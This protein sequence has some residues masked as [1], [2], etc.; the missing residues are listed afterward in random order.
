[1]TQEY[2]KGF[3]TFPKDQK[4][5]NVFM[6]YQSGQR[7][8]MNVPVERIDGALRDGWHIESARDKA[9]REWGESPEGQDLSSQIGVFGSSLFDSLLMGAPE[10]YMKLTGS[11]LESAKNE[12]MKREFGLLSGL[13]TGIG[14]LANFLVTGSLGAGVKI[15]GGKAASAAAA[16]ILSARMMAMPGKKLTQAAADKAAKSMARK[17]AESVGE[18]GIVGTAEMAP[19]AATEAIWGDPS[20]AGEYLMMGGL[21]GGGAGGALSIGGSAARGAAKTISKGSNILMGNEA[22]QNIGI[23]SLAGVTG[24]PESAIRYNL[25]NPGKVDLADDIIPQANYVNKLRDE[26]VGLVDIG[27]EK[28]DGAQKHYDITEQDLTRNMEHVARSADDAVADRLEEDVG[29]KL[30]ELL[31]LQGQ[32]TID[33]LDTA[34]ISIGKHVILNDVNREIKR[35]SKPGITGDT[36]KATLKKLLALHEDI[37]AIPGKGIDGPSAKRLLTSMRDDSTFS[38]TKAPGTFDQGYSRVVKGISRKLSDRIK[39]KVPEY[40]KQMELMAPL[41]DAAERMSTIFK[42]RTGRLDI[43][44]IL[45]TPNNILKRKTGDFAKHED[46]NKILI[47]LDEKA[48]PGILTEYEGMIKD[49]I[50]AIQYMEDHKTM[51]RSKNLAKK[52]QF[53]DKYLK[54]QAEPL[55]TAKDEL[56]D[57]ESNYKEMKPILGTVG[58]GHIDVKKLRRIMQNKGDETLD[59]ARKK[60]FE[61]N[62][63]NPDDIEA[64]IVKDQFNKA[65]PA[66]SK[67]VN[68][69]AITGGFFGGFAGSVAGVVAGAVME[70]VGGKLAKNMTNGKMSSWLST[71]KIIG[72]MARKLDTI[73]KMIRNP[74]SGIARANIERLGVKLYRD[75]YIEMDERERKAAGMTSTKPTPENIDS[76]EMNLNFWKGMTHRD[77]KFRSSPDVMMNEIES[78]TEAISGDEDLAGGMVEHMI[79]A[80]DYLSEV[81]PKDPMPDSPFIEADEKWEPSDY[82]L[83]VFSQQSLAVNNP[84]VIVDALMDD[85]LTREMTDAVSATSPSIMGHVQEKMVEAIAEHPKSFDYTKRISGSYIMGMELD[86]TASPESYLYYQSAMVSDQ[87]QEQQQQGNFAPDLKLDAQQ[88][89][90]KSQRIQGGLKS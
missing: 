90:T 87:Q 38:I 49:K 24:A 32:Q 41:A 37:S 50:K 28:F 25:K 63:V 79:R 81:I 80:N 12:H 51:F 44:R 68:T 82:D 30:K 42:S 83:D 55:Q 3:H 53:N 88:S 14:T 26:E 9:A 29:V 89:L 78:K 23:K 57:I 61:R 75:V 18:A 76:R 66:G 56:A 33:I 19:L 59:A 5:V 77:E 40:A 36:N 1:M 45:A 15:A 64:S 60:F 86:P 7:K 31:G 13:G 39:K 47:A 72:D 65:K 58:A 21:I 11:P 6:P 62:S 43:A 85:S 54:E 35:L 2:K 22:L 46:I 27:K 84:L 70:N 20:K 10:N 67:Y 73:P 16:K 17:L 34:D 4:R 48:S 8:M 71:E 52:G 69:G 74:K